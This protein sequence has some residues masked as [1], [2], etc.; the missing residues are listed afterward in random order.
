MR[1]SLIDVQYHLYRSVPD[2][3]P[4]NK[5]YKSRKKSIFKNGSYFGVHELFLNVIAIHSDALFKAYWEVLYDSVVCFFTGWL[6]LSAFRPS[7][8]LLSWRTSDSRTVWGFKVGCLSTCHTT[9]DM[10]PPPPL[11]LFIHVH[12]FA[13]DHICY[14]RRRPYT[15]IAK[16]R[17]RSTVVDSKECRLL[18]F[19]FPSKSNTYYENTRINI[20]P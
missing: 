4:K 13:S 18:L 19:I 6:L 7:F 12:V 14:D 9:F 5:W 2:A 3:C 10:R 15:T 8:F 20:S 17:F 1:F 16:T 11:I